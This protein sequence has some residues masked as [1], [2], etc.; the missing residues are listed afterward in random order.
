MPTE[1]KHR[2]SSSR[3][4]YPKVRRGDIF[5]IYEDPNAPAIGSEEWPDRA[6]L[7]IS[8]DALCRTSRV[9]TIVWLTTTNQKLCPSHVTVHSGNRVATALCEHPE[10]ADI[11]RFGTKYGTVSKKEM[12][13]V[14]QGLLYGHGINA[15]TNPQGIF[16]KWE[17]YAKKYLLRPDTNLPVNNRKLSRPPI[18][19]YTYPYPITITNTKEAIAVIQNMCSN[20]PRALDCNGNDA[21]K[22]QNI[23][24]DIKK[25][26]QIYQR[27]IQSV[28]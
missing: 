18:L 14:E 27:R 19:E 2:N 9:L 23:K 8:A 6:G 3:P 28:H 25:V 10:S 4:K 26:Y 20:C 12:E 21:A 17:R 22:C 7:V 11:S 15:G 16:H 5:Y 13:E 24:Q 1:P